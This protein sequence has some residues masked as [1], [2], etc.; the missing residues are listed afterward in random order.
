MRLAYPT[1]ALPK[2]WPKRVKS[3]LICAIA[4]ARTA[5]IEARATF[6]ESKTGDSIDTDR[7]TQEVALLREELRIKDA[8][9]AR[10][11]PSHRP[12]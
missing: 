11:A 8:R 1:L 4:L 5:L 7:L 10:I 2:G 3:A 9:L 12:H 6:V